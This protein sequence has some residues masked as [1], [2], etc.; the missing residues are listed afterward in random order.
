MFSFFNKQGKIVF[1][2]IDF[3]K[4]PHYAGTIKPPVRCQAESVGLADKIVRAGKDLKG[5][6]K[7]NR[8]NGFV[9]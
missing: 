8:H 9:N 4:R 7:V 2:R 6:C 3:E 5:L 1:T